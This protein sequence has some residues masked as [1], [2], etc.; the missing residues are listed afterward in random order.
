MILDLHSFSDEL[1]T[2]IG[3]KPHYPDICIGLN[4]NYIDNVVVT[5]I[6]EM[7]KRRGY[8]YQINYPYRGSIIP[9]G[10]SND[11]LKRVTSIMIEVNKR[12]YL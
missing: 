8:S 1:A 11:E 3:N 6:K 7:I 12:I 9:N 10:L 4:D 5:P 2:L